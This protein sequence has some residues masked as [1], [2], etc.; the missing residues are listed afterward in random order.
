MYLAKQSGKNQF[1]FFDAAKEGELKA[2]FAKLPEIR[3]ALQRNEFELYYQPKVN[4][5]S[6]VVVGAEALIRWNHPTKGV[7]APSAFLPLVEDRPIGIEVSKWVMATAVQQIADWLAEGIRMPVSINV[8][9]QHLQQQAFYDDLAQLLPPGS[10]QCG[11]LSVEI[12]ETTALSD[13]DRI[14]QTMQ[15]CQAI[16]VEF[17][18]DDFGTGYSSLT[19]LSNLPAQELKIDQSFVRRMATDSNDLS[20]VEGV[21][22]LA[23]AFRR[24]VTAEGVESAEEGETLLQLG[25]EVAQGYVIARPMPAPE[26]AQWLTSWKQPL[27][28]S[29]QIAVSR[30]PSVLLDEMIRNAPVGMALIDI[31]GVF[32]NVNASYCHLYGYA[33]AELLGANFSSLFPLLERAR[34]LELNRRFIHEGGE[35]KGV[36]QVVRKDGTAIGVRVESVRVPGVKNAARRLV[37][38]SAAS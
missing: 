3:Q 37:Y 36:W 1:A 34:M 13:M 21:I 11:M 32:E 30:E 19:Y 15:Q 24:K 26:M 17:A 31:H 25:C 33:R 5:K 4:M 29:R 8:G 10:A 27:S 12:L 20:I 6:G 14:R 23:R 18:L 22:S 35:F 7:L 38:V 2:Q 9:A 28:W 16:G